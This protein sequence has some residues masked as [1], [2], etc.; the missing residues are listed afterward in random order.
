MFQHV[1]VTMENTSVCLRA[2]N[3]DSDLRQVLDSDSDP[4][5][6][7]L[8][9]VRALD[10]DPDDSDLHQVGAS[11]PDPQIKINISHAIK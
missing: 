10:P 8:H 5:D 4:D 6:S 7:D 3:S 9:L 1:Q 2:S 11:D